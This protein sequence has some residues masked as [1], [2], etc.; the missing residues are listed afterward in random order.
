[1]MII[2]LLLFLDFSVHSYMI[3]GRKQ[4]WHDCEFLH[5]WDKE[6]E[7]IIDTGMAVVHYG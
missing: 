2:F 4:R 1:M 5:S 3:E 7:Q 6:I